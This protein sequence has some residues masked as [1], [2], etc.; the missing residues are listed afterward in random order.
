MPS[1]ALATVDDYIASFPEPVRALLAQV[2]AT[3]RAA[4]PLAT[5]RMSYRIPTLFQGENLVH[6]AA[7]A[8]HIGFYPGASGIGHFRDE[9]AAYKSAK[10]SVQFPLDQPLPLELVG[11]ITTFRVGE[12]AARALSRRTRARS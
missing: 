8:N 5:E 4:A 11:R 6:F 10:G 9:L 1:T 2:R 3:V 12:A 7:F